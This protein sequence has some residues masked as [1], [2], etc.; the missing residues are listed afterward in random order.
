MKRNDRVIQELVD[1]YKAQGHKRWNLK[2]KEEKLISD[3]LKDG[4]TIEDLKMAVDGLHMTD[5]NRGKN[6]GGKKYLGL[7]YALHEDK[8]DGRIEAAQDAI[9]SE[10]KERARVRQMAEEDRKRERDR[11]EMVGMGSNLT[12]ELRQA[13]RG[14]R[15]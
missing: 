5:W 2:P 7:Y 13:L 8:I 12:G 14:T 4:Y 6:P 10:D 11:Q 15:N 3:R 9:D 1:Y